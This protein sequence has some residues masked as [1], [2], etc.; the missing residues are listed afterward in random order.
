MAIPGQTPRR[1]QATTSGITGRQVEQD[2]DGHDGSG[3]FRGYA[4]RF[5]RSRRRIGGSAWPVAQSAAQ[6]ARQNSVPEGKARAQEARTQN[7]GR[8]PGA[9]TG[10]EAR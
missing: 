8:I 9:G 10:P 7:L 1:N 2:N 4:A 6:G 5:R 3:E